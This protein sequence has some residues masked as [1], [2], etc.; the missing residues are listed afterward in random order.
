MLSQ[1]YEYRYIFAINIQLN[2]FKSWVLL[3]KT[4]YST[5]IQYIIEIANITL[6][7][8]LQI[9]FDSIQINS[10]HFIFHRF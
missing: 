8:K 10:S 5:L 7:A 4:T 2:I 1:E 9:F 6:A 3:L